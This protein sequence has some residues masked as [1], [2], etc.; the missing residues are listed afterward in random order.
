MNTCTNAEI[1]EKF[2]LNFLIFPAFSSFL[3]ACLPSILPAFLPSFLPAC[4]PAF[5]PACLFLCQLHMQMNQII[6]FSSFIYFSFPPF[7][8]L[9]SFFLAFHPSACLPPCLPA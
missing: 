3:S 4:F 6:S 8:F 7:S 9:P 5:L 1:D 2:L